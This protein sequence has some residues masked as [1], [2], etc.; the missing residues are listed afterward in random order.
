MRCRPLL[1]SGSPGSDRRDRRSDR[2]SEKHKIDAL[3]LEGG[4][5][6]ATVG[7]EVLGLPEL[8]LSELDMEHAD[9]VYLGDGDTLKNTRDVE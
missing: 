6:L 4:V 5:D 1:V 7:R 8:D 3:V 9:S 2:A